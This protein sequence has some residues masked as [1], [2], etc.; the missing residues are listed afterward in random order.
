MTFTRAATRELSDR[1]RSRLVEAARCFRG[2]AA[3]DAGDPLLAGL[4][5]AHPPGPARAA[6]AWRLAMAAEGMDDAA[7]HTI[8][9]WCQRMLREHAFDS[10]C[11][12]DEKLV[13]DPKALLVQACRDYWRQHLYRLP[14]RIAR[15]RAGGLEDGRR[16]DRGRRRAARA[17]AARRLGRRLARRRGRARLGRACGG[18]GPPQGRLVAARAGHAG[19]AAGEPGRHEP[20]AQEDAR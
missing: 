19:V 18:A 3:P 1:I 13:A 10:G 8:D 7:V 12:F 6:A 17:C 4:L 11:L 15:H 5:A 2:E 16:A 9:A 14:A 20:A